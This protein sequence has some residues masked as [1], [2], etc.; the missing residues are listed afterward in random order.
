MKQFVKAT[1]ILS[2]TIV[3]AACSGND[4]N[5]SSNE[6][7]KHDHATMEQ[8]EN[9][10]AATPVLKNDKLNAVYQH[11]IH[12]TTALT[13][14]DMSEAKIAANA[15]EADAEELEGGGGIASNAS[16]ITTASDIEVQRA[17]F[18]TMSKE[19]E[20]LIK[21]DGLSSGQLYVDFCPMALNDKG[22]TWITA[23]KDIRNPYF[24]KKML[25]CGEV[26]DTLK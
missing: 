26:Q 20:K 8:T 23:D 14:S 12:L 6:P 11:Y 22:A 19:M 24:G 17:A 21:K 3:F 2:T 18:A 25:E 16:K 15:I 13:N 5:K 7:A 9:S 4:T 10:Q 1:L